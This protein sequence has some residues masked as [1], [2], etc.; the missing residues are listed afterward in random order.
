MSKTSPIYLKSNDPSLASLEQKSINAEWEE[1]TKFDCDLFRASS[2]ETELCIKS[3]LRWV[4]LV[5]FKKMK[6][7]SIMLVVTIAVIAMAKQCPDGTLLING[8]CVLSA[9]DR[10]QPAISNSNKISQTSLT[11]PAGTRRLS[12]AGEEL[13]CQ[14]CPRGTYN[15]LPGSILCQD[16]PYWTPAG[17][18]K[19]GPP[20]T[21]VDCFPGQYYSNG[22]CRKCPP[23][24]C[25]IGSG[26]LGCFHRE[27]EN[28][29]K[30]FLP[31]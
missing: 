14:Q 13:Q 12:K 2:Q 9:T 30:G 31:P 5:I 25:S 7:L 22:E 27:G 23:G 16:C 19:C 1:T 17:A 8:I 26:A 10:H 24:M 28:C 4:T 11:C 6:I 15:A 29:P 20:Q 3:P 21:P 18:T